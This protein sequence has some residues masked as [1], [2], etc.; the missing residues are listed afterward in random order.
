MAESK[1]R[2]VQPPPLRS[3]R[4]TARRRGSFPRLMAGIAALSALLGTGAAHGLTQGS[5]CVDAS[6]GTSNNCTSNDVTFVLVGL[7]IQGDGCVNTSDT[8]SIT[9]QAVV[10]NTTAQTRYD[11]GLWINN[12]GTSAKT[13]GAT[14][15]ARDHLQ[16]VGTSGDTQCGA[17]H[18]NLGSGSGPFL[19]QDGDSCGDL[20][21]GG[22]SGVGC[23]SPWPDS[24]YNF[25]API[26]FPCRDP[27]NSGFVNIP[28]CATWGNQANEVSNETGAN[29]GK[30]LNDNDLFP[31]TKA[32]CNCADSQTTIPSPRLGLTCSCSPGTV[33]Q[34]ASTA[35]TVAFN[36]S[37]SCTPNLATAERFRCGVASFLRFKA[38]YDATKGSVFTTS[39]TTGG[40]IADSG[41]VLTWTPKDLAA[42]GG[43]LGV[44]A[45][46]ETGSMTFQYYVNPTTANGA[47]NVAVSSFW[48]NSSS[49]SPEVSQSA[50][51]A[52]CAITVSDQATY[53]AVTNFAAREEDGRVV[54]TWETA[55]E[56]GTLAFELERLDPA[57]G[58]F[59]PV[60]RR[61]LPAIQQVG[62]GRYRALDSTAP[63]RGVARY[64]VLEIEASGRRHTYGPFTV[65]IAPPAE[66]RLLAA[67][68]D[69]DARAKAPAPRLVGAA[70]LAPRA[71]KAGPS[72]GASP[73]AARVK[74]ETTAEG[75]YRLPTAALAAALGDQPARVAAD[76]ANGRYRLTHAGA[77]IAWHPADDGDGLVFYGQAIESSSAAHNVY[78]LERGAGTPMATQGAAA[79]AA[80]ADASFHDTV[81]FETD[82]FPSAFA[83][84]DPRGDFWF[85]ASFLAGDPDVGQATLALAVPTPAAAPASLAVN[86]LGFGGNQ[87]VELRWNGGSVGVESWG[88]TGAHTA[89]FALP[90]GAL[91]DGLNQ[92]ELVAQQ[93]IFFLDSFDLAYAR[94]YRAQAGALRFR[95]DGNPAVAAG[96]F[97][98]PAVALYALADPLRPVRLTGIAAQA[99]AGGYQVSFVPGSPTAT[100]LAVGR[101][102]L[103]APAAVTGV[104]PSSLRDGGN[105]ASYV[106]LTSTPL[107]PAAQRLAGLRSRQGLST[108]VVDVAEVIDEFGD[109]IYDPEAIR[110]FLRYASQRWQVPPRYVVLAGKGTYD[111][112]NLLGYGN[113][114]VPLL[115]AGTPDGLVPADALFGDLDGDGVADLAVGR[116]PAVTAAELSAYVDKLAAFEGA[117]A[118]AGLG[119]ATFAADAPDGAGDF[120][121]TSAALA[122]AVAAKLAVDQVNLP[123]GATA[124]EL[125][126]AR[127]QLLAAMRS[128][129]LLLDYV[130]HGGLDRLSS[131]GLLTSADVGQLANGARLPL[132]TAFTCNIGLFAYPS[133]SSLGEE[134]VLQG[135]GGTSALFG[136]VGLSAN[137]R[138]QALGT[139]VLGQIVAGGG[140]LGDRLL[141]GERAYLAAGGDPRFLAV[142]TLLGDPALAL[143]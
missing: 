94:R 102:G 82:A 55:A 47:A 103:L 23:S 44:I 10:R 106:V 13:G 135:D 33:R 37:V 39:E 3:T 12:D 32:K 128:G 4:R 112:R 27:N 34:G 90:A 127:A 19:N 5:Y 137:D 116:V 11:I 30:C 49:F 120:A 22:Q 52:T 75:A 36:N 15:C 6:N 91:H 41:T 101:E 14:T 68:R 63:P 92:V 98:S 104:A 139:S 46:G 87:A 76:L 25:P 26:T 123:A 18:L 71:A 69:F 93:G 74:I 88:G 113:N 99:A 80:P 119:Q 134:L 54:A 81:H 62:G 40:T 97:A 43:S 142:Y 61:A 72:A 64:R 51:T 8:V 65:A 2:S 131:Q 7:G 84:S 38:A 140:R 141:R 129:R 21:D 89:T 53:A 111:P 114:V 42:Q 57:S 35:C 118:S 59:L 73:S 66:H 24:I 115:L 105:A 56:I 50:L 117:P 107:L 16:P 29:A 124:T 78:W 1:S 122:Q 77:A 85:W 108:M 130:G 9:L 83:I 86:L 48:S 143:P 17:G 58:R 136:P 126:A 121:A 133:V 20:F 70:R 125:G 132:M 95:G 60:G 45:G 28:T 79:A 96:G 67:D 31:G 109:G 100:Y 110:A 138:A